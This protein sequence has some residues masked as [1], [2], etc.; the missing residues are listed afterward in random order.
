MR[1]HRIALPLL[2]AALVTTG[3]VF[4]A[5]GSASMHAELSDMADTEVMTM[6]EDAT[7]S[8]AE[9]EPANPFGLTE[10]VAEFHERIRLKPFGLFATPETSPVPNDRFT[11]FHTAADVEFT[12]VAEEVPVSA[13]AD[14]TVEVARL[15]SG[16]GGVVV[17]RHT[18]TQGPLLALYGHLDPESLPAV[19]DTVTQ[20]QQIAQLG[21]TPYENGGTRKH[22]HFG[23]IRGEDVLLLGY[24]QHKEELARW[25][26]PLEFYPQTP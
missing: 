8:E 19:G 6:A 16:Y 17:I 18:T 13:I 14:G 21:D 5:A 23:I 3:L 26:D 20:G 15:A 22:L 4:I 1:M 11:G 9:A 12:D 24:V 2:I 7:A 25:Y 10:P